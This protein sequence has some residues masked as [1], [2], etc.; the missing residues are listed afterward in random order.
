MAIASSSITESTA[1]DNRH[2]SNMDKSDFNMHLPI[3]Y[4]SA[5]GGTSLMVGET[6]DYV[7][8]MGALP[9]ALD[10]KDSSAADGV[11]PSNGD[12]Y[13]LDDSSAILT[14]SAI[15]WQSS[16]TV[17]YTFSG[18]PDLSSYGT[19]TNYLYSYS[20][21]NTEHN[22][23]FVITAINDGS[24]YIEV[25]NAL[26]TDATLDETT[27]ASCEVPHSDW[28]GASNG[29]FV[30][31]S[32]ADSVY[33]RI[34]PVTGATC[35][36]ETLGQTRTYNGTKWLGQ[37]REVSI[38]ASDETTALAVATGVATFRVFGKFYVTSVKAS[39]TTAPTTSGTT[40]IDINEGGTTILSTKLT[41]DTTEKTTETAATAAV[42]SDDTLADDSEITID[43]DAISGGGTEA[44]LKV[45]LIG[46]YI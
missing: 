18:S 28:S 15:N 39:L 6:G 43:I 46:H 29:D 1:I 38:A 34:S 42:I 13:L 8:E 25:T 10:Y 40:T 7:Y 33:Y 20:A 11:T 24:D 22:G 32:S 9:S 12:V 3:G 30:R 23:R 16:T 45:Y 37:K 27:G 14:V 36:D 19:S 2:H 41:I 35:Y 17:R 21:T 44:G 5:N 26:V 31:Y 4:R